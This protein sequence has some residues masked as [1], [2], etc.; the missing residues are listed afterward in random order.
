MTRRHRPSLLA[1]ALLGALTLAG[2]NRA[3]APPPAAQAAPPAD[4]AP[5]AAESPPVPPAVPAAAAVAVARIVG[6]DGNPATGELAFTRDPNGG[7]HIT[8][9]IGGLGPDSEHGF[10]VH[11]TGDCS[12]PA[13]GS[14]GKHF[15]PAAQPHGGPEAAA[16]H[17]G[18]LPNLKADAD[19]N[20]LV[21]VHM[22]DVGVGTRDDR[23]LVGRAVIVHTSP[24]DYSTQPSGGSGTP[25][26][27]G[28]IEMTA[29]TTP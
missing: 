20:A 16:R 27:C 22:G 6:A 13:G 18:D 26:A 12:A 1:A 14:A 8:G 2:C 24:D 17:S 10:H 29:A 3:E 9:S 4:A 21:D 23:D 7:V 15:N 28:V 25:I 5:P 11:E 19:G